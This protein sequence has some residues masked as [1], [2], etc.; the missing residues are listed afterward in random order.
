MDYSPWSKGEK[1]QIM[2]PTKFWILTHYLKDIV[3]SFQKIIK[4]LKLDHRTKVWLLK[5]D[6][7]HPTKQ[8]PLSIIIALTIGSQIIHRFLRGF[9]I[10]YVLICET[11]RFQ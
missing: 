10:S 5:D 7:L 9:R 4:L 3:P 8:T 1:C 6:Q 11:H 2:V